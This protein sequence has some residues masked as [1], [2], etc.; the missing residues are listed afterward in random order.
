M[1]FAH[2]ADSHIGGWREPELKELGIKALKEAIKICIA[3]HTAFILIS[4]DL[5]NTALP[6]IELLRETAAVLREAKDHDISVYMI[7]GSHDFSPSGKT[8]LDV[9]EKSGL[10]EIVSR[11][12]E[13]GKLMFTEDKTGVKITGLLGKKGGLEIK[14]Y[15][16]LDKKHL[17]EESG[18]KIWMFHTALTEFKPKDMEKMDSMSVASLPKNFNYYAGGHVHYVFQKKEGNSLITFPGALFPNNFKELEQFKH[19][20]FYILDE[21]LNCEYIPVKLKEVINYSFNADNKTPDEVRQEILNTISNYEGKIITIRIEG[22][23]KSGKPSDINF[24]EIMSKLESAYYVLKNTN[25]LTTKEFEELEIDTGN[26]EEI[27]H[28]IIEEHLGQI[29]FMKKEEEKKITELLM[30][31]LNKEKEEGEKNADF[32]LRV[33]KDAAKVLGI[34][35]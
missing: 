10:I 30:D 2:M 18:F 11:F 35:L 32:E 8:M 17:E 3:Q 31:V 24:K 16:E 9:L 7:P 21:K 5:F 6:P 28:K 33:I 4:G 13:N 19:G 22:T 1:K 12:D 23:L 26:V 29:E 34:E 27:E 14:D 15:E 25:K 20:G